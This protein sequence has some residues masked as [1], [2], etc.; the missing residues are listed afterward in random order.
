MLCF[1]TIKVIT[2]ITIRGKLTLGL[3]VYPVPHDL[4]RLDSCPPPLQSEDAALLQ[5]YP[6]SNSILMYCIA[7]ILYHIILSW[8]ILYCIALF[9]AV[10]YCIILYCIICIVSYF[11]ILYCI[12]SCCIVLYYIILYHIALYRFVLHRI[13][14][15]YIVLHCIILHCIVLYHIVLLSHINNIMLLQLWSFPFET[16]LSSQSVCCLG[17]YSKP[18]T[19]LLL[20]LS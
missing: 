18:G 4:I 16:P 15:Y 13:L 11:S 14:F 8:I 7:F 20:L 5:P 1:I 6:E 17:L 2:I 12:R 19:Q 10:S 9:H 3:V